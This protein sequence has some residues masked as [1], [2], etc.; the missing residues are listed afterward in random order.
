MSLS[1][2]IFIGLGCGI[3]TG[4]FFGE[5]VAF[6]SLIADGFIALLQ[7]TVLPYITVSLIA[8]LGSLNYESAKLLAGRGGLVLL[9]LWGVTLATVLLMPFAF[10]DI[11]TAKFFSV[12]VVTEAAERDL[13]S[14]YIPANPFHSMANNLIPG[15][16]LFSLFVGVALIGV[17]DKARVIDPLNTFSHALM[18]VT[19]I[20]VKLMPFGI[21]AIAAHAA[22]T[23][24]VEEFGRLQ[25]YF[26]SYVAAAL[27]LTFWI[28][29]GLV[30]AAVRLLGTG[31]GCRK[32]TTSMVGHSRCAG[33]D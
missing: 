10:P 22:G 18:G 17:P 25:V 20:V 2:K 7:M 1:K 24:S 33:L 9:I 8:A 29:P 16:V 4:L 32:K 21:F 11:E 12:S 13:I 15:V 6:M 30:T 5:M 28:L 19:N 23:L 27:I 31:Q 14:H 3:A 26:I